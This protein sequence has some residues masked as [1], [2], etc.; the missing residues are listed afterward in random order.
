MSDQL[1]A[2]R[3]VYWKALREVCAEI[4]RTPPHMTTWLASRRRVLASDYANWRKA[5]DALTAGRAAA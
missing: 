1:I 4:R 3:S 2:A 5:Y